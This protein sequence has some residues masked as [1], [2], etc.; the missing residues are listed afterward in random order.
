MLWVHLDPP[1]IHAEDLTPITSRCGW[2]KEK[3]AFADIIKL[4]SF[5]SRVLLDSMALYPYKLESFGL[6]PQIFMIS[7]F[8]PLTKVECITREEYMM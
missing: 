1:Q 6:K 8:P 5:W 4:R 2:V 3:K 7:F